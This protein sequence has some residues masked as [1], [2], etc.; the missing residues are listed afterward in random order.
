VTVALVVDDREIGEVLAALVNRAGFQ[1]V[2]VAAADQ[3]PVAAVAGAQYDVI[4]IS[5]EGL[6]GPTHAGVEIARRLAAI[7]RAP[8]LVS[9]MAP[10]DDDMFELLRRDVAAGFVSLQVPA[11]D[12]VWCLAKHRAGRRLPN[13]VARFHLPGFA[14]DG[15]WG[16]VAELLAEAR[17]CVEPSECAVLLRRLV[18]PCARDV[19]L[20]VVSSGQSGARIFRARISSG[21]GPVV[22]DLAVK[23]GDRSV[24]RS[25]ALHYERFVGPL[26][27]GVAAQLRSQ[28]ETQ[29]LGALAYSWVGDSVA[30][31]VAMG[32][33]K[34]AGGL[35]TWPRRRAAIDRLFAT[36]LHSWYE[37]YRSKEVG[38]GRR[39]EL[40][41]YYLGRDGLWGNGGTTDRSL[42]IKQ[43]S[44]GLPSAVVSEK[45]LWHFFVAEPFTVEYDDPVEWLMRGPVGARKVS[46]LAPCHGDLHVRNVYLLPDDSPRLID[47]GTTIVGHVFRD[48]AALESSLRL[49]CIGDCDVRAL[50]AAEDAL[51]SVASL[52]E[53]PECVGLGGSA[54]LREAVLA[55]SHIRRAAA[56][57]CGYCMMEGAA[58]VEYLYA[59]VAHMLRYAAGRV[60]EGGGG[61]ADGV[62]LWHAMY[63]AARAAN[64]AA[65]LNAQAE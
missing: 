30:D 45:G 23:L 64:R 43:D 34:T 39:R 17:V 7:G 49:T 48:F 42:G 21:D 58:L 52:R 19:A 44:A 27:D 4:L 1:S 33:R 50:R 9:D 65:E 13:C 12:I 38:W 46:R 53:E 8:V 36:S 40:R 56:E 31:G 54:D 60:D 18:P 59:V 37:I 10:Q 61:R 47:F 22:E 62:R 3:D 2:R 24:I 6:E 20:E 51:C 25:E 55:T 41:T 63:A 14:E 29:H 15:L 11:E 32:P 57:A 28:A 35:V 26:P 5:L 16:R